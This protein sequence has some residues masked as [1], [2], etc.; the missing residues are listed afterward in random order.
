MANVAKILGLSKFIKKIAPEDAR[1]LKNPQTI[2]FQPKGLLDEI[3]PRFD[4]RIREQDKLFNVKPEIEP[5]GLDIPEYSLADF[6]GRPF[7]TTMSD[8]TRADGLLMGINDVKFRDYIEMM[9]GQDYMFLHPDKVWASANQPIKGLLDMAEV[10]KV[11]TKKD[12]LLIPWRMSPTGGD[13][14]HMTGE[15]MLA[16]LQASL[17]KSGKKEVDKIIKNYI[18]DWHG[19]DDP[20]S[21]DQYTFA[22]NKARMLIQ[23]DLD[24]QFRGAGGLGRGEARVSVTDPYQLNARDGGIQNVGEIHA[25]KKSL[26]EPLDHR[27]YPYIAQGRGIGRLTDDLNIYELLPDDVYK[28]RIQ[29]RI[30]QGLDASFDPKNPTRDDY[31]ALMMKPYAG[32]IDEDLLMRL[33]K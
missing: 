20:M 32:I 31:R 24:K 1:F 17:G 18:P 11:A 4:P 26:F 9:G 27:S 22:S 3:D 2:E 33:D 19:L 6:E 29:A 12:P 21:M 13:F 15:T 23:R 28:Q 16:Y 14:S 10:L 30:E 5:Y 8:R 25:G 7:I